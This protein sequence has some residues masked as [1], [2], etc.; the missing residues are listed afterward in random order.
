MWFDPQ[1]KLTEIK[2]QAPALGAVSQMSQT[3]M[4][5]NLSTR[6]LLPELRLN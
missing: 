3:P 2:A 4:A 1:P 5:R 6:T